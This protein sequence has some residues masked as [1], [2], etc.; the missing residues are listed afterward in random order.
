MKEK[1]VEQFAIE[2]LKQ[3]GWTHLYGPDIGPDSDNPQRSSSQDVLLPQ[4]LRSAL[5][6]LNPALPDTALEDAFRQ[7]ERIHAPEL[8]AGNQA[9]HALLTEGVKVTVRRDGLDRGEIVWLADFDCPESNEFLAVNQLTVMENGQQKRPDLVL[10][11]NGLPLAVIELKNP[12]DENATLFSAFQQLQTYKQ[13]IPSLFTFNEILIIADGLEARAGA[14]S[15]GFSRFMAWKTDACRT[16]AERLISQLETLISGMLN[17]RTLLDLV[18]SFIVFERIEEKDA[19]PGLTIIRAVK[20]LAASHQYHAVNKA[21]ESAV[22]AAGGG[23]KGGVV[24]HTQGSGK[25]LSMVFFTGKIVLALR[26]PTVLVIT[27][28][29]DLDSQLFDTFAAARQLLRQEPQQADSRRHLKEL[30]RVGSGGVV[31]T[32]I[33]KFQPEEGGVYEQLSDRKNI[34]VIADEAH[35]TQYGFQAKTADEK[36]AQGN[37]IGK[38]TVYGFAKHLR[39]ALP[40]A[41]YLGFTGT[42]IEKNDVNTP[43]VFGEYVDIY[44]IAQAVADGS[45]VRIFYESRLAKVSL[46]EEGR[47]LVQELDDELGN[48]SVKNA[49]KWAKFESLIGSK[50]RVRKI[51]QDIA[52]HFTQREEAIRG[53]GMIVAMSRRIAAA[54]YREIVALNPDWHHDDLDKG[55]VKVVM[56]AASSDGPELAQHHTNKTQRSTLAKRMR[57]PDDPLKLVIVRDMWLTGFDAPCLPCTLTSR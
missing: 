38:K 47:E 5:R 23:G 41:V 49:A 13:A 4:S 16:T 26:N 25:S 15:A 42:P 57:C 3:Q 56:T 21:V 51:A 8:L 9:F 27:D 54:L 55:A 34:V 11:V 36:D 44:D 14:L 24:W 10:F 40:N 39:D 37:V 20:K 33:Q 7:V 43:A 12:A 45:T 28:R 18:R 6:C 48:D 52:G 29:N 31:F 35:R 32:T 17:K 22:R 2:L 19:K 50:D 1:A 46:T 53:K 30:L